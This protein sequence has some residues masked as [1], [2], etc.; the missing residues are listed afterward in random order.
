MSG[1]IYGL[2]A[3]TP[4]PKSL[5]E[6]ADTLHVAKSGVSVNIRMLEAVGFVRRAWVKGDRRDYYEV[7]FA[8]VRLYHD[9]FKK[10]LELELEPAFDGIER[11]LTLL[12]GD[13]DEANREEAEEI[14]RRLERNV[15]MKEPLL[16][17]FQ[18]LVAALA[19]LKVIG[20]G[21][22]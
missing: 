16:A 7:E 20:E 3:F 11:C 22:E 5:G 10:G 1:R 4:R 21:G 8:L 18:R 6:I 9:F 2:L 13:V 19:E 12:A 15:S 17:L 14:R